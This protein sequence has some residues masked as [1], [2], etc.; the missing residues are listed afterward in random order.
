MWS[1]ERRR[2]RDL[3]WLCRCNS[4]PSPSSAVVPARHPRH[5]TV[6][7]LV[8]V[9]PAL[10]PPLQLL[11]SG[12]PLQREVAGAVTI[13]ARDVLAH[14]GVP[15]ALAVHVHPGA[16]NSLHNTV[17]LSFFAGAAP[18]LEALAAVADSTALPHW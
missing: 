16:L 4:L 7:D 17:S 18:H 1:P 3:H 10:R 6:T 13:S 2:R 15:L 9:E 14:N 8:Q 5:E 11:P 12:I